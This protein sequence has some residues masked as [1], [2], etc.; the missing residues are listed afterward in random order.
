[1]KN[2]ILVL[3]ILSMTGTAFT[4]AP[5]ENWKSWPPRNYLIQSLVAS[6]SETLKAFHP[7]TG[8]FGTEPWIC[9]DQNVVLPLA[10]A[11]SLKSPDNPYYHDKKLLEV[12][13]KGGNALVDDQDEN[14][15][16]IFRKKDYS[17]WGQAL[18]TWTYSRWIR[19]YVLVKDAL[20]AADRQ[21]WEKGLL[22][23][24]KNIRL[25]MD[26]PRIQN[27]PCHHA[28]ALYIAGQ[29]F[30]NQDWQQAAAAYQRL[31]IKDQFPEGYWTENFG[32]VV[33]YN[34][35]Y[36]EALGVYYHFSKDPM[37]PEALRRSVKFHSAVLWSD[38]TSASTIDER[39]I[40]QHGHQ[41]RQRRFHLLARRT[42]ISSVPD[43]ALQRGEEGTDRRRRRRSAA[44]LRR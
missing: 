41:Y 37:V 5:P 34:M 27:I 31:V 21:K 2:W 42:G 3:C 40:Y 38:G 33:S 19:A 44:A 23:G 36:V 11:W 32:P 6:V 8:R 12:I 35:V 22:L 13:A 17:T 43:Q 29:V 16:W 28:M 25:I 1:M 30:Q 4:A 7:E 39:V 15:M 10:A 9:G 26:S 24:F 18:N 14:G 20:P